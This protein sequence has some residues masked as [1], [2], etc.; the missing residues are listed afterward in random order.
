MNGMKKKR[1]SLGLKLT[2]LIV[3]ICIVLGLTATLLSYQ[4][5]KK[6]MT[7]FYTQ[8]GT[9]L[10]KTL[11]SQLEPSELDRYFTEGKTDDRYLET[12]S[13]ILELVQN[14]HVEYLYVVRPHDKG[15][16]FLFDSD[17]Q[18]GETYADG[19]KCSLGTY[20][21]LEGEFANR[22][23]RFLAGETME[24]IVQ[25]DA[26]YGWLMTAMTPVRHADGRMAGYVMADISM[27]EVVNT[28]QQFLW[29]LGIL[30][31]VLTLVLLAV[32]LAALRLLVVKPIDVLT[33]ATGA[34]IQNNHQELISGKDS[35]DIPE[36][37]TGDEIEQLSNA[38]RKM[39]RDMR[40]YIQDLMKMTAEKERLGAELDVAAD[41]QAS[42]LPSIFPAFPQRKE[43]D[44]YATM[45]PA[46]EVGGDF[47]DFFMVDDTHLAIVM[48][49]V[50]GKGIPASLF[51]VI[52]K[53]LIKDHTLVGGEMNEVFEK[54]NNLLCESNSEGLFIT[55]FEGI[56]NLETGE[57]RY[58]N[59]GHEL[60]YICRKGEAYQIY[61]VNPGFVLAG[62]ENIRYK[63][64]S[65]QLHPG[66]R[67][68]Q[69]TDGVTEATNLNEELYGQER[70]ERILNRNVSA[71][72]QELLPAIKADIEE[73]VGQAPQFD[74]ITML[75][76][77][78]KEA[79]KG[80][81]A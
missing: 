62:M 34:F 41:I 54:V 45:D 59:A 43:F 58:V 39:Q 61:K 2:A 81:G 32:S 57:F 37:H 44:I 24:P 10:V 11:A 56:L 79:M 71:A 77:L 69:Y 3:I 64:G 65:L 48:A 42:M 80:K 12:Q 1:I 40:T 74:D 21:D 46:K 49:D 50:S 16:T 70:L 53:T 33:D 17:M 14:N 60:P 20:V 76:L 27:N 72:P 5:F 51:M 26:S 73:F 7:D 66:D 68:F 31:A 9:N 67:L 6:E 23:P 15:V 8:T 38:F 75:S 29:S 55:A 25:H 78:Y 18:V 28:R 22:I 47:Y 35:S 4:T 63:A 19:G 36:I 13:F 52:G 30:L